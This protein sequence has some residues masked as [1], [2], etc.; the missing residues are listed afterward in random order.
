MKQWYG[1]VLDI[2]TVDNEK[3]GRKAAHGP[4]REGTVFWRG[5]I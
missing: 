4:R 2:H 3:L 5:T 1:I